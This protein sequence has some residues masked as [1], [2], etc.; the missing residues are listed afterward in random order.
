MRVRSGIRGGVAV[1]SGLVL[2]AGFVVDARSA[3]AAY[4]VAW[5]AWGAVPIGALIIFMTS[6]LVRRRWTEALHPIFV[7]ATGIL[8]VVALTFIPVLLFLKDIYPAIAD[9]AS[10]PPFK[11]RWLVPWFFVLRTVFY[12]V[13]WIGLAEWLRRAWRND[14]AMVRAASIGSIVWTLTVSFAGID[15][16]ESLE[17]EFHSSIY[18]LIYLSFVLTNGTAFVIGASLLSMRRIGPSR[19]YSGL[20]LS[21]LLLWCY[22]HAMQYIV[23]WSGNIPK[24][25]TW[26]LARS[27]GGW[28][29]VLAALSF[30]Q[31]VF[32]FCAMLSARVRSDPYWLLALCG[33]TLAMRWLESA[34]LILP[35]IRGLSVAMT[36]AM[37]I[38][39]ALFL[40]AVLWLAFDAALVGK[41]EERAPTGTIWWRTRAEAEAKSAQQERSR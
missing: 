5:I 32:P 41:A 28:Q 1:V 19:S 34:I 22:L 12:F 8:P 39:A 9:A 33:L 40:G 26:S 38:A 20:L 27:E 2:I 37:L 13:V 35:A 6:Y 25:V 30:G 17:P 36:G 14:E 24:E 10:L 4:L 3:V 29:F 7:A 31:F 18:G 11:A 16:M 23:I 21:V 15:W